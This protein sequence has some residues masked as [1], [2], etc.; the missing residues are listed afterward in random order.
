MDTIEASNVRPLIIINE[1]KAQIQPNKTYRKRLGY[2]MVPRPPA[3]SKTEIL[4]SSGL[5][6]NMIFD[7]LDEYF[8]HKD[9]ENANYFLDLH[10][11]NEIKIIFDIE[12][13]IA[14]KLV[15]IFR[16]AISL[17]WIPFEFDWLDFL[18]PNLIEIESNCYNLSDADIKL[19][20]E[21]LRGPL[22]KID[23]SPKRIARLLYSYVGS[24][25]DYNK[26]L[27]KK[28]SFTSINHPL[29]YLLLYQPIIDLYNKSTDSLYD[30]LIVP[31][32]LTDIHKSCSLGDLK[33]ECLDDSEV[34]FS[35][36]TEPAFSLPS[37]PPLSPILHG[38]IPSIWSDQKITDGSGVNIRPNED[39]WKAGR[40]KL[41]QSIESLEL[42]RYY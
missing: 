29:T 24:F 25:I 14:T 30:S 31:N 41:R 36:Y 28:E 20:S 3:K 33:Y 27:D 22:S 35:A 42:P 6:K 2:E 9:M 13:D 19:F 39:T 16:L 5:V 7:M 17:G 40:E 32:I 4:K 21:Y 11:A 15:G 1:H 12:I 8:P 38:L 26:R 10:I 37:S 34:Y 18:H 23:F